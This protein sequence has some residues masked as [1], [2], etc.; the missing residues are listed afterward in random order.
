MRTV[1]SCRPAIAWLEGCF[2]GPPND[3]G[4]R[5]S[6]RATGVCGS[7]NGPDVPRRGAASADMTD[8]SD[9]N[10]MLAAIVNARRGDEK[11]RIQSAEVGWERL[12]YPTAG[13]STQ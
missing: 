7:H 10:A 5:G 6:L 2:S 12:H 11:N 8:S 3:R 9:S 1:T 13:P 4:W